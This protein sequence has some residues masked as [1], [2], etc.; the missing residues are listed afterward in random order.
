V[1]R[2]IAERVLAVAQE[3]SRKIDKSVELVVET[4][5]ADE[6]AGYGRLAGK[7]MASI[8]ENLMAPVYD[9]YPDLAPEWYN[10]M[11]RKRSLRSQT[12]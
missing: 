5:T 10:E 8:F 12:P 3:C 6:H 9:E 4:C 7:M 11:N 1:E 2:A